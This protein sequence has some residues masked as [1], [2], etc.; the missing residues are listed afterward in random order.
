MQAGCIS[1][2]IADVWSCGVML[3]IMLSAAYPFGRP[4]DERLKPS[5]RMHVM[6]QVSF[7]THH[8]FLRRDK[9]QLSAHW[10][11]CCDLKQFIVPLV[12]LKTKARQFS[13]QR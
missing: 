7:G 8:M 1:L 9:Q 3:Y 13:H 2:Q 12:Y 10:L 6:L 4:E 11:A 5:R